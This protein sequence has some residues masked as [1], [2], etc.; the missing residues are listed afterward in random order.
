MTQQRYLDKVL[1]H[2]EERLV[3]KSGTRPAEILNVY[4]KFLKVEEHRLRM[5][6]RA[7]A[8]GREI[9]QGRAHV[10]DVV[11]R[12]VFKAAD[13]HYR[14][15]HS[16]E[17][18]PISL[19]AIGGYGRGE[20]SPCSDIDLMFL[21]GSAGRTAAHHPYL[22]EIVEQILYMLWDVGL[23][24]GHSTR[25]INE[26][27]TQANKDMQSKTSMIE[28]RLLV[29][30]QKI[31]ELFR[32]ALIKECVKG[33][34]DDYIAA[35]IEDQKARHEKFGDTVYL[36][37]PNVK[38]GCGGLRDFQNLIW[39]SFFKYGCLKLSELRQRGFL[40]STEQR[41]LESA[42]DFIL[43]VRNAMHYM[44]NRACD[45]IGI[46][47]QPQ[48]AGEFGYRQ[49]DVLRR[50]EA[51][52]RDYY[53]HSRNIFLLTNALAERLALKPPKSSRLGSLL[54]R[55]S[56]KEE[57]ID[58]F[59]IR[60]GM[61][62]ASAPAIFKQEP[63]RLIRLFRHAQQREVE[64]SPEL[65]TQIRQNLK[66]VDR[67]FQRSPEARDTFLGI[68]QRKGQVARILRLMHEV[69]FLG[70]FVPEFGRLTCLV[71]HEFFHRYT[72]DEHTLQVIEHLDRIIDATAPPHASYKRIFQQIAHPHVLYL[73]LL[74]HDVGKASNV[75]HHAE[76]SAEMAR[77]VA[78]RLCLG[79]DET[80]QLLF[81]VRDHLKLSML[82]QRR[83]IDDQATVDAAAR[84]AKDEVNLDMLMLLTFADAAGTSLKTWTEWKEAL[85]WELYRRTKQMLSGA[86]R[87]RNI[88][89]R[90]IEQLYKEV[91]AKLKDQL[92]LEEIYSHFELMPASYYIN[93]S[94][95]E[96]AR[97]L[98]VIH[99]FLTRQLEV[100]AAEDALVPVLDWQSLPA[101]SC[102][103]VSITTWDRLGLFSKI[104]GALASA[105]LNI[106]RA[107]VY[108]R[109]DHVVL[110][111]FDVCDKDL[112]AVTDQRAIQV[113]EGMLERMLA[114]RETINFND[115]L[116][117]L[118]AIR[119]ATPKIREVRIPTTVEFDN[120]ISKGRTIVEIQ[121][122]DRLGLLYT[123]THT[124]S[125]VGLDISFAKISTEK[126]AAID[127]FYVQDQLGN[128]ITDPAQLATI[129]SKLETS[130]N[131]LA[132]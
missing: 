69:E 83:D 92:P 96:V 48:I 65:R 41:Q 87:A 21:H 112:A 76:A 61:I 132:S 30:D 20:L 116:T 114:N 36:Q 131:L 16:G 106:L 35:R 78:Q 109:G 89:S 104:C 125:E 29:G 23:K 9:A 73:A 121:T 57:E 58:G 95:E 27:I 4:K 97:H 85:L 119:G 44:T 91:S 67:S 64:L 126:G 88:L 79:A 6:H 120:E 107:N 128:K 111:V 94:A 129:R 12:H 39:M 86:E 117:R 54:G 51:F 25:S 63:L 17:A 90:R 2:A 80:A 59:V 52:M 56:R 32:Q 66:L 100:E 130:I 28:S 7:G 108:T 31:Y 1:R 70:K 19:V 115:V 45:V 15:A 3:L 68:L 98:M 74:L 118:R 55:R 8:G 77:Q 103:Q 49:H 14:Q 72:A 81:L 71:Q 84:V 10:M 42:Y 99:R 93:T 24:V 124:L 75:D 60:D 62:S 33:H 123:I 22:K 38:S 110:D 47:L 13:D 5:L 37:E 82:S 40:E 18:V 122:E 46:G 34:E 105:E 53:V 101:Q 43:R 50:T 11:L 113:A 102:S 127:V 26:A